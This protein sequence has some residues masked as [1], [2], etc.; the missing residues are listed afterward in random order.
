M[1]RRV[2]S[3]FSPQGVQVTAFGVPTAEE[4]AHDFLWREHRVVPRLRMVGIFNRSHYEAVLVERVHEL[5]PSGC[6]NGA[7]RKSKR[8]SSQPMTGASGIAGTTTTEPMKT[9]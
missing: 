2:L 3:S 1:I 5:V 6:G 9:H 4:L 8:G 7:T